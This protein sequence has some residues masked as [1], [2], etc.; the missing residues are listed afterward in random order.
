MR[1]SSSFWEK[2]ARIGDVVWLKPI[3]GTK[4]EIGIVIDIVNYDY[5]KPETYSRW[6][7]KVW[8]NG[9]LLAFH[10]WRVEKIKDE[11]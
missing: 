5:W 11:Y 1:D 8:T 6:N 4:Y 9:R 10:S 7:Y 2:T 3:S